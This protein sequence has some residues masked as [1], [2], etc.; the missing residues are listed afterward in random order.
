V[1]RVHILIEE[2]DWEELRRL[3]THKG[4]LTWH[5]RLAIRGYL[6]YRRDEVEKAKKEELR[7]AP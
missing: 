1:K 3:C 4:D 2:K 7:V 5:I 6:N